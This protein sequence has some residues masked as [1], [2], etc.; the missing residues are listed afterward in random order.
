MSRDF[1]FMVSTP[2]NESGKP[3]G[4][5]VF[6]LID[7][8]LE[9]V[10][11]KCFDKRAEVD[12][13]VEMF[14]YLKPCEGAVVEESD[15]Q[16]RPDYMLI[17]KSN[18]YIEVI[19]NYSDK[20]SNRQEIRPD[21][22]LRCT[23]DEGNGN[24]NTDN[25]LV[26][27][28]YL[29]GLLY[30]CTSAGKLYV[31]L[32]NLPNDYIQVSSLNT[33]YSNNAGIPLP[34][35]N[36]GNLSNNSPEEAKFCQLIS[37][38]EELNTRNICHY[39]IPM[40]I[41]HLSESVSQYY[42]NTC[43]K[44]LTT[45]RSSI[46][47]RLD[48]GVT[49]F[50]INP[51]DRFSFLISSFR[52]PLMIRKI[53]ISMTFVNFLKCYL[54]KKNILERALGEIT[55]W[56]KISERMGFMNLLYM[57]EKEI[58]NEPDTEAHLWDEIVHLSGTALLHSIIVWKQKYGTSRDDIQAIFRRRA[59]LAQPTLTDILHIP[60]RP[61][62]R[63]EHRLRRTNV[64]FFDRVEVDIPNPAKWEVEGFLRNI[65]KNVF[66]SDF[67]VVRQKPNPSASIVDISSLV[68]NETMT[69]FLTDNYR[70]MDIFMIDKYL[71]F[72]VF[73]PKYLDEPLVKLSG[74]PSCSYLGSELT[75]L[76]EDN[77][78]EYYVSFMN[79][80][81]RMFVFNE[82]LVF[83]FGSGGILFL[84][85]NMLKSAKHIERNIESSISM[86]QIDLGLV[87]DTMLIIDRCE[88]CEDCDG[89]SIDFRVVV[90]NLAG[91]IKVIRCSIDPHTKFG[92]GEVVDMLRL[93][94]PGRI[95]DKL[96]FLSFIP[97]K[98]KRSASFSAFSDAKRPKI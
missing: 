11:F 59:R 9:P 49:T 97:T 64:E 75:E 28:E 66:T 72:Q 68:R 62:R 6:D 69:S 19:K 40:E 76:R 36:N 84:D 87:N 89:Y 60:G 54:D 47:I 86:I 29:Q 80:F 41:Y 1:R 71:S 53:M 13:S 50:H 82:S 24:R 25:T 83:I 33:A 23:P 17:G 81:K 48:H 58:L 15:Q 37:Y 95:V 2:C 77:E 12:N 67:A 31:F 61:V 79:N 35:S 93:A 65:K 14:C 4:Y 16:H 52:M 74:F 78:F 43:Y 5:R 96:N 94:K 45:Y 32:L 42:T 63:T 21:F 57:L 22:L 98:H 30:C 10:K 34:T 39:L 51:L 38:S 90:S 92:N 88:R 91:E 27:L 3:S 7:N 8:R 20:I 85:K 70:N 46:Y 18:G 44:G 55:S 26:G 73:R 56:D